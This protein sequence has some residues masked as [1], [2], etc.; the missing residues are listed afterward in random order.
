MVLPGWTRQHHCD[1]AAGDSGTAVVI[2]GPA[3]LSLTPILSGCILTFTLDIFGDI[4]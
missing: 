3:E 2:V 1:S 4:I